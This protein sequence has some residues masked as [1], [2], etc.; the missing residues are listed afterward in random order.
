[1]FFLI[2]NWKRIGISFASEMFCNDRIID[3]FG[4][5]GIFKYHVVQSACDGLGHFLPH[6][7][8]TQPDF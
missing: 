7:N 4:L 8:P 3:W 6:S 5:E 1:M 2:S